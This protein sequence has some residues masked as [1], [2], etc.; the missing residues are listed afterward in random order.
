MN[1]WLER[2]WSWL[3]EHRPAT[4]E[5]EEREEREH[6]EQ[7]EQARRE[8]EQWLRRGTTDGFREFG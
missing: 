2:V 5:G 6:R 1:A 4:E 8:R 7:L 3:Q